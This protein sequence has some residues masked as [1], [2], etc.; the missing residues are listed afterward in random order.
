MASIIKTP[1]GT[2]KAIIRKRGF[3]TTIKTF[4][5]K[6]DADDWARTTEDEMVRGLYIRRQSADRMTLAQA[7]ERYAAEVTPTKKHYTQLGERSHLVAL[8]KFFG[9]YSMSAVTPELVAK[10]RDQR[11]A[12]G[13]AA[14]TVRL[15][16]ALLGHLYA[17]AMRE[18]GVGLVYNPVRLIRKPTPGAVLPAIGAWMLVKKR[19]YLPQ[20]QHTAIPC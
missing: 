9:V 18:W 3:P 10:F 19:D 13:K 17:V 15:D 5:V 6:R 12:D 1:S 11:L 20:W 2:W 7:L 4:R 8:T 14:N 16:L